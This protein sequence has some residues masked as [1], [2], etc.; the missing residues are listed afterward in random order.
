MKDN[1]GV[2][3]STILVGNNLVN[4]AAAAIATSIAIE[5]FHENAIGIAIGVATFLILIFGDILPKSIGNNNN[6]SLR[7]NR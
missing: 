7:M 5:I 2:L 3:L 1:P 4:V 6:G